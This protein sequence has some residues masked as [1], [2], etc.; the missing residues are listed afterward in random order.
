MNTVF[1]IGR[2]FDFWFSPRHG[3]TARINDD[4]AMDGKVCRS[5]LK[6]F[7]PISDY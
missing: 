4:S 1:V 6:D 5:N 7:M 2:Y 3:W